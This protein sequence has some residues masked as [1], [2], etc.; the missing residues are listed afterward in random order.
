MWHPDRDIV[1][2]GGVD[3]PGGGFF[4]GARDY[5]ARIGKTDAEAQVDGPVVGQAAGYAEVT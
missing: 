4:D 3:D 2:A 5:F 1:R